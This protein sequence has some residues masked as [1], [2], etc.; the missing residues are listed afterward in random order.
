MN[1]PIILGTGREGRVSEKVAKYVK[2]IVTAEGHATEIIDPR[3]YGFIFTDNISP[4]GDAYRQKIKE[5]DALIIVVPEYN[6]GYPGDL[7][8]LLDTAYEEYFYKSVGFCGVSAGPFGG[9]RAIEQ[10]KQ[11]FSELRMK[12]A[13][14]SVFFSSAMELFNESGIKNK[15]Y[16]ERIKKMI[17]EVVLLTGKSA[18]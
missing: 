18:Q 5:A 6:H 1:I 12:I 3:D 2:E 11:V 7:K 17:N 14:E 15:S 13:R 16:D 4:R 9:V 8:I 10:L